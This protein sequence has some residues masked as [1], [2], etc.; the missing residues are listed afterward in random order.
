MGNRLGKRSYN[1]IVVL[2]AVGILTV[3]VTLTSESKAKKAKSPAPA[4]KTF[5]SAASWCLFSCRAQEKWKKFFSVFS[6]SKT[7]KV[8]ALCSSHTFAFDDSTASS[9]Q[10]F[11][12]QSV[13][14][15]LKN[16]NFVRVKLA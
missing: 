9:G 7:S 11:A 1:A 12:W 6:R 8:S 14:L 4:K 13:T 16:T 2:S 3:L 10:V 15:F 5:P